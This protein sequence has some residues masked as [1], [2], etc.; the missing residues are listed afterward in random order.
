M[1]KEKHCQYCVVVRSTAEHVPLLVD[2]D[3]KFE[4]GDWRR[5]ASDDSGREKTQI[6]SRC[7]GV[8]YLVRQS[9]C[10]CIVCS[11]VIPSSVVSFV[12]VF[13][14]K[15]RHHR[16]EIEERRRAVVY[17]VFRERGS[18]YCLVILAVVRGLL[19]INRILL[20]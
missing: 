11:S 17:S 15:F 19:L 20:W 12:V 3:G 16:R 10:F 1:L 2:E 5:S 6:N 7:R 18:A 14:S 9:V 13:K 4:I 8:L